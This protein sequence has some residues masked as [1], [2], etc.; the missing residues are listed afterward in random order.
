MG[1]TLNH[2]KTKVPNCQ[3][4]SPVLAP[5]PAARDR[6]A[7]HLDLEGPRER[8]FQQGA[9][10]LSTL[11]LLAIILGTGVSGSSVYELAASLLQQ[12][13]SL[14][15]LLVQSP[16]KLAQLPGLGAA[17]VAR[18]KA[19]RELT[20]RAAEEQL[21]DGL[22]FTDATSVARY[23]QRRIGHHLRE[24]FGCMFLDARH[25]LLAWE[26]LFFGSIDKAHVHAREIVRRA[27]EL[28]AAAIVFGH[29]HPSGVAEPS[30]ADIRLTEDLA[31]LLARLDIR[32][33]DHIVVA[34]GAS[35]S[36]ARRGL[37][38]GVS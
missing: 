7:A 19:V 18:L 15:R 33:L 12:F 21:I 25:R 8:L 37:I 34:P 32:L 10:H 22:A 17:K 13:D 1:K 29:N 27:L 35:V 3:K 4:N 23:I 9:Q 24:V 26:E 2:Q 6:F 31:A 14:D 30:Q 5:N 20:I 16:A 28:N 38:A 11:D 36:M